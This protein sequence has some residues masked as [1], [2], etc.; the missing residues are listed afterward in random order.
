MKL[1]VVC[2]LIKEGTT[3]EDALDKDKISKRTSIEI[4]GVPCGLY[5]KK[6]RSEPKW[7]KL[8]VKRV[9]VN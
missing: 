1:N 2:Y 9:S 7:S 3:E 5:I 6:S 4:K 8:L